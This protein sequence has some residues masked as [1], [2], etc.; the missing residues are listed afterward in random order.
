[1]RIRDSHHIASFCKE[2]SFLG[3]LCSVF[4]KYADDILCSLI[5]VF[6]CENGCF[7]RSL[8]SAYVVKSGF[9]PEKT[10]LSGVRTP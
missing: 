1:M 6:I 9:E 2:Y 10:H 7:L 4:Y 8:S 3:A 5:T